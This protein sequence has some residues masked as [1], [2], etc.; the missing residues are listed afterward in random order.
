MRNG[1]FA[2]ELNRSL[3]TTGHTF[4]ADGALLQLTPTRTTEAKC[5]PVA[6][7]WLFRGS[8]PR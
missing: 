3:I 8:A 6:S 4:T 7:T 2:A 1:L 5:V